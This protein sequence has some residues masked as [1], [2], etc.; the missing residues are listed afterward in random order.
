V[1]RSL[2]HR[3][4]IRGR[5]FLRV[6]WAILRC[7]RIAIGPL[8]FDSFDTFFG[9]REQR[10]EGRSRCFVVCVIAA[11]K[12]L[13]AQD[14]SQMVRRLDVQGYSDQNFLERQAHEPQKIIKKNRLTNFLAKTVN[15]PLYERL[16]ALF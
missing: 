11:H 6:D 2:D 3:V 5:R 4:L 1:W 12:Y 9:R 16:N 10:L 14:E 15:N 13:S 8:I 7:Q